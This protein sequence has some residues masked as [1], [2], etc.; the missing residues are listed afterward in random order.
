MERINEFIRLAR[1]KLCVITLVI[2]ILVGVFHYAFFYYQSYQVNEN[3]TTIDRMHKEVEWNTIVEAITFAKYQAKSN[4]DSVANRIIHR[5]NLEYPNKSELSNQF[6]RG[7][8]NAPKFLNII[9]TETSDYQMY[10]LNDVR[11]DIFVLSRNG[12]ILDNNIENHKATHRSISEEIDT[13]YNQPL[14]YK[15]INMLINNHK[16]NLVFYE[17]SEPIE[18]DSHIKL[19]NPSLESLR[20][21]F[22]NEGIE[23]LSGYV[24]LVPSYITENGDIFGT[25]DIADDGTV[26]DNFKLIIVQRFSLYDILK[27]QEIISHTEHDVYDATKDGYG[28]MLKSSTISYICITLLDLIAICFMIIIVTGKDVKNNRE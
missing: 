6:N 15:A 14:G 16:S 27:K 10:G 26:N 11:N 23:G 18:S 21:I 22:E 13:H 1:S 8:F 2:L 24:M 20:H 25:P 9:N 17:P 5:I 12:V 7:I 4:T 28:E 3:M 19:Q